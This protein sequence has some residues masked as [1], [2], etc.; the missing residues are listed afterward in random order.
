MID[1]LIDWL[2]V[3]VSPLKI[4][5]CNPFVCPSEFMSL[6]VTVK[7]FNIRSCLYLYYN[8]ALLKSNARAVIFSIYSRWQEFLTKI[9]FMLPMVTGRRC[10]IWT[11][12]H[13]KVV[14][15]KNEKYKTLNDYYKKFKIAEWWPFYL[16]LICVFM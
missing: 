12:L 13:N 2:S 8:S 7:R 16:H 6:S 3:V 14:Q 10:K 1:W 9:F 4:M 11:A 15:N 5:N